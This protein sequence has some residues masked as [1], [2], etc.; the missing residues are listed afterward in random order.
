MLIKKLHRTKN[1][2][3]KKPKLHSKLNKPNEI[4]TTEEMRHFKQL[5]DQ[6]LKF[7]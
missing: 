5:K 6:A 1:A 4:F 7:D 3:E 2:I